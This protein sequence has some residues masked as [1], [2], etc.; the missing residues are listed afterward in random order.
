MLKHVTLERNLKTIRKVE[1]ISLLL[2]CVCKALWFIKGCVF[3]LLIHHRVDMEIC[4]LSHYLFEAISRWAHVVRIDKVA[5]VIDARDETRG[6]AS[7]HDCL[8]HYF[9]KIAT[10]PTLMTR[11]H[12]RYCVHSQEISAQNK[13]TTWF[14]LNKMTNRIN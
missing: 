7:S 5:L 8:L 13:D 9:V 12:S 14:R 10:R 11:R 3:C 2:P 1:A 4:N 6:T